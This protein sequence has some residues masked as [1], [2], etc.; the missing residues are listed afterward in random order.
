MSGADLPLDLGARR[1]V[2]PQTEQ[3]GD[4]AGDVKVGVEIA[5]LRK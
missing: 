3:I 2:E 4:A 5:A 1:D